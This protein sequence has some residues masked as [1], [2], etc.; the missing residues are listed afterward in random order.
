MSL[1]M[2]RRA[3]AIVFDGHG[4]AAASPGLDAALGDEP[5][6]ALLHGA[7]AGRPAP[8]CENDYRDFQLIQLEPLLDNDGLVDGQLCL[9]ERKSCCDPDSPSSHRRDYG[10][11]FAAVA[12][13]PNK[14][15]IAFKSIS[16][17]SS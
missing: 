16:V 10:S 2:M 11:I 17:Y 12:K 7:G 15:G 8:D 14:S 1:A 5:A 3:C 13:D 9:Q 4:A 6:I